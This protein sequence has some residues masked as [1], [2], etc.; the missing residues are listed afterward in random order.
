M[1]FKS[2]VIVW[3]GNEIL[4]SRHYASNGYI[5]KTYSKNGKYAM[6]VMNRT[7]NIDIHG[8]DYRNAISYLRNK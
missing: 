6:E 3:G 5:R 1:K 8:M 2:V 7:P 4:V